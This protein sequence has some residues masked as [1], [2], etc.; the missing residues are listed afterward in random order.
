VREDADVDA[1]LGLSEAAI[2]ANPDEPVDGEPLSR[3]GTPP[4]ESD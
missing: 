4:V 1:R 2:D 3:S